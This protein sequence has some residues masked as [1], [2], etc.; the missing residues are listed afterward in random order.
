MPSHEPTRRRNRTHR[1]ASCICTL[2]SAS[3]A[4]I[5]T[6]APV[7]SWQKRIFCTGKTLPKRYCTPDMPLWSCSVGCS[8][9]RI[10]FDWQAAIDR[11]NA[12]FSS[13]HEPEEKYN[14]AC[15]FK[16]ELYDDEEWQARTGVSPQDCLEVLI[17]DCVCIRLCILSA[18]VV[19]CCHSY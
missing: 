9:L 15:Y 12:L 8:I 16:K 17:R 5:N 7:Y 19:C 1:T 6:S 14:A 3:T 2:S 11:L 4:S 18:S 10:W 13:M